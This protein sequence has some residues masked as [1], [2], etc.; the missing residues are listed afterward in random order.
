MNSAG[1]WLIDKSAFVRLDR[2]PE[3]DEWQ[4]QIERGMVHVTTATLLEL[5]HSARSSEEVETVVHGPPVSSMP[6]AYLN[7]RMED[8]AVEVMALMAAR[9]CHR[10]LSVADILIAAVA[11][12][13]GL[14]V[15]HYDSDFETIAQ[16]TGQPIE[17]VVPR[18]SL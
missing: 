11:E 13:S 10:G 17:W 8:R 9:G 15:L 12:L 4:N 5:G 6:V 3:A 2:C 16:V 18:G 14:T 1:T 7:P